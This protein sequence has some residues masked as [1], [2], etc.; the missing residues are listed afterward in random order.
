MWEMLFQM[1]KNQQR[2]GCLYLSRNYGKKKKNKYPSNIR[3]GSPAQTLAGRE[4]TPRLPDQARRPRFS[5]F[6][7]KV[8]ASKDEFLLLLQKV[9]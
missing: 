9:Q 4:A 8:L 2:R 5:E 7:S 1:K 6:C 3:S